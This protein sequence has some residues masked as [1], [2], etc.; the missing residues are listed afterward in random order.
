MSTNKMLPYDL[1]VNSYHVVS[2]SPQIYKNL[3]EGDEYDQE[4]IEL[5]RANWEVAA[6]INEKEP[7]GVKTLNKQGLSA[8]EKKRLE[9]S[10]AVNR[11]KAAAL[12]ELTAKISDEKGVPV[13]EINAQMMKL[14][15]GGALP[16]WVLEYNID[17]EIINEKYPD[18]DSSVLMITL[19]MQRS[20]SGWTN[21]HS[22][23]LPESVVSEL[24]ESYYNN[25]IGKGDSPKPP[26]QPENAES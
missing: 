6:K 21:D 8:K 20:Y 7:F 3:L 23:A 4:A 15:S 12:N 26:A 13:E 14:Q 10:A 11:H 1:P 25:E 16:G 19:L 18:Y 5:L 2:V 24:L 22:A 17:F 9:P